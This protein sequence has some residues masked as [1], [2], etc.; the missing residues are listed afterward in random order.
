MASALKTFYLEGSLPLDTV[1]AKHFGGRQQAQH[2]IQLL[3]RRLRYAA[4]APGPR[5]FPEENDVIWTQQGL[6]S[7]TLPR[8][9]W[10]TADYVAWFE[11]ANNLKRTT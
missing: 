4:A 9:A 1:A 8:A 6:E 2:E 3:M 7:W 10:T 11:Q 5:R